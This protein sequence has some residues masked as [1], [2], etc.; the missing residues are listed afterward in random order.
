[1]RSANAG[2]RAR[3]LRFFFNLAHAR[4]FTRIRASEGLFLARTQDFPSHLKK[5]AFFL[6]E[7][8]MNLFT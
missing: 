7:M 8:M 6:F 4:E 3:N 1:M 2:Y 5:A